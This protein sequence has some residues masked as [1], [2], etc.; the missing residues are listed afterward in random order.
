MKTK[1]WH[2]IVLPILILIVWDLFTRFST[3]S[4]FIL[5]DPLSIAI[6]FIEN[7]KNGEFFSNTMIS[8]KRSMG[9]FLVG[10]FLGIASGILIGWSTFWEHLTDLLI[11]FVRSVPKTALAPLFIVWF[12]IGDTSKIL[13]IAFSSYFFTVIPTIEGVKNVDTILVKS[14]QSMGA[15]QW[16]IMT[17]VILPASLP[18]IFAGI[19]LA[20]TTSLLVLVMVEIIAGNDGLGFMLEEA[21]GNLNMATMFATLLLLGI[22]GYALD[23]FMQFMG[24]ILMPW[25][26]G[27]TISV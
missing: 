2:S 7:M 6:K 15:G 20:V 17:T 5:P 24:K 1:F 16:Q 23:S 21:R 13:L 8:L 10:S 25:R 14:A 26:K 27:K 3:I 18:S 22:L 12:G 4:P 11:N 19:R 9:G